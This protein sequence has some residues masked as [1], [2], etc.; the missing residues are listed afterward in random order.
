MLQGNQLALVGTFL[1]IIG[2]AT[3]AIEPVTAT[4]EDEWLEMETDTFVVEYKDGYEDDAD[5]VGEV[6]ENAYAELK[7][8]FPEYVSDL[9]F[10]TH[11]R[12]YPGD[13]WDQPDHVLRWTDGTTIRIHVQAPSDSTE[14]EDWYDH[15]L[16]HELGNQFLWDEAGQYDN[17]NYYQR[18]P[19]WFHQG[20]TEYYVYNTPTVEDQFP[21]WAVEN[22][23][24]TIEEGDGDFSTIADDMY[25]GGHIL[26]MYLVDEYGEDAVWGLLRSEES[27]WGDAVEAELGVLQTELEGNWYRWAE[28]NIGGDYSDRTDSL[29]YSEAENDLETDE[30]PDRETD[31]PEAASE[32]EETKISELEAELEEKETEIE[33]LETEN[34]K[35]EAEINELEAELDQEPDQEDGD[36]GFGLFAAIMRLIP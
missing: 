1:M 33:Q 17:Y 7:E 26:S 15:G 14:D 4:T 8:T 22:L 19:S 29:D 30:E 13:M 3:A 2:V 10:Q 25:H 18:N 5:Y 12:V 28:E 20:L 36:T 27:S 21:P 9:S 32:N 24:E 11:I 35:L 23:K 6:G 31:E 34:D 16:A